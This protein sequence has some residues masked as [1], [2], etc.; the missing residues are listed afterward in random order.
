MQFVI[1]SQLFRETT[2]FKEYKSHCDQNFK[3][4]SVECL[5]FRYRNKFSSMRFENGWSA[6]AEGKSVTER[7]TWRR[8]MLWLSSGRADIKTSNPGCQPTEELHNQSLNEWLSAFVILQLPINKIP[9]NRSPSYR[10]PGRH[11]ATIPQRWRFAN[12]PPTLPTLSQC[13]IAYC[14]RSLITWGKLQ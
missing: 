7:E 12:L 5:P 6:D 14:A 11:S 2:L 13:C 10:Q 3:T 8:Y 4:G 1:Y 9:I